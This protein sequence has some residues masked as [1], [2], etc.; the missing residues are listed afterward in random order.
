MLK[1]LF[2]RN[3]DIGVLRPTAAGRPARVPPGV[4]VY[5]VG[6]IHGRVDLLAELHRQIVEDAFQ[7]T[8]RTANGDVIVDR[9]GAAVDAATANGEIRLGEV[10]HGPVTARSGCGN[11]DIGI[12]AGTPVLL[13][14]QTQRGHVDNH[15]D[16]C[17]EPEHPA[18]GVHV[19][20]RTSYGDILIRRR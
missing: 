16:A 13:D 5:A 4:C 8:R 2:R 7:G 10:A 19:T 12:R 18:D 3:A 11:V 20:A 6:D 1:N 15:L 14:L 17:P 9:A